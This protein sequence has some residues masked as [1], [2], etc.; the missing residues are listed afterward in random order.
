MPRTSKTT[1]PA[2]SAQEEQ[3]RDQLDG[4]SFAPA[5]EPEPRAPD[6]PGIYQVDEELYHAGPGVSKSGL[7]KLHQRTPFHFR[8]GPHKESAAQRFGSATHTAVLEPGLFEKRFMLGPKVNKNTN[9]WKAAVAIAAEL[10]KSVLDHKEWDGARRIRDILHR[11]RRVQM[12]T[13][14]TP[15]IEQS[16][17]W[18]DERTGELCRCRPDA[19]SYEHH[20]IGDLK[21]TTNAGVREFEKKAGEFGYHVQ[22]AMY[23]DGWE[24]AGGGPVEAFVFITVEAEEPHAYRIF[25]LIPAAVAEGRKVMHKALETYHRCAVAERSVLARYLD[26]DETARADAEPEITGA[27]RACWHSYPSE[28]TG[29]DIPRWA[30]QYEMT[31]DF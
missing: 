26:L 4:Q 19:Y 22:D 9:E 17:Y 2:L 18:I 29:I 6:R 16:G 24:L 27:I 10:N 15:A 31:N 20:I 25:E 14:G 21:S 11:D 13:A 7:W 23:S 28:V 5:P 1:A 8:Y 12:L 3:A 30:Y